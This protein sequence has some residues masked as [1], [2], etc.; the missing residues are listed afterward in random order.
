MQTTLKSQMERMIEDLL[1]IFLSYWTSTYNFFLLRWNI[2]NYTLSF[3]FH[4]KNN[5]ISHILQKENIL[6]SIQI[7]SL[8]SLPYYVLK[9]NPL[10]VNSMLN[11]W[12]EVFM[13]YSELF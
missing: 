9:V 4:D 2:I 3:I 13:D 11:V 8:A 7:P 12:R 10:N 6:S 1:Y 5:L